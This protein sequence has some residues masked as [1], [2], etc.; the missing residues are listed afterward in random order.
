MTHRCIGTIALIIAMVILPAVRP[1]AWAEDKELSLGYLAVT[2]VEGGN[3]QVLARCVETRRVLEEIAKHTGAS[4]VFDT[5]CNTYVSQVNSQQL[6]TP[7]KWMSFIASHGAELSCLKKEDGKWHIYQISLKP[8]YD[9]SL[10]ETEI[11]SQFKTDI[12]PTPP[13]RGGIVKG[14]VFFHGKMIPPPYLL[15][16][17]KTS[18]EQRI[19]INNITVSKMMI[20]HENPITR[21]IPPLPIDGQFTDYVS[22]MEYISFTFYPQL[23]K[24]KSPEEARSKVKEFLS[25]QH[26][27]KEI[28]DRD[29][30]IA[31]SYQGNNAVFP[32]TAAIF[33]LNYDFTTGKI[34][35]SYSEGNLERQINATIKGINA[36]FDTNTMFFWGR[37]AQLT[38]NDVSRTN[39]F[40]STL[41]KVNRLSVLQS[42][43]LLSEIVNDR[44]V[45]RELAVNLDNTVLSKVK[46]VLSRKMNAR[47]P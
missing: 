41:K 7:E 35:D 6:F 31:I 28:Q 42:E 13:K 22:L 46:T 5:P 8:Q 9:A 32:T 20:P 10:S 2:E 29:L 21:A 36:A 11:V 26:F 12:T 25:K 47:T 38:F 16:T 44:L 30:N 3:L 37:R 17:E 24:E 33:P 39:M 19:I 15:S 40:I 45:A 1:A 43:C 34:R 23:L 27:V 14:L 18:D 4:V